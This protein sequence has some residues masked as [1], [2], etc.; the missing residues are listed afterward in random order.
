MDV[1]FTAHN[2]RL[3][4]G[5]FTNPKQIQIESHPWF[6]SARRVLE[7]VFPGDKKHIRIADL[8]CLEGGYTVGFARMGFDV[9]GIEIRD[10]NLAACEYVRS[11]TN[12]PNL[13]FVKDNALNVAKYGAFDAVFCC[14]LFYHLD[15]PKQFL[16]I[17]SSVTTKVLILQTHF[18]TNSERRVQS[19]PVSWW[20]KLWGKKKAEKRQPDKFN[21]SDL[22]ENEGL[23]GRWFVEF[24]N[25]ELFHNREA[26]RWASWDN[27]RSFWIQ[28]EFLLQA[29]QDAG[30]DLVMEQYDSLG[31][32]I[33][34]SMLQG[35]YQTDSRGTFIGIKTAKAAAV[36]SAAA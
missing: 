27:R 11:K 31:S 8:G 20:Q 28:R 33:A 12:L 18:S 5:T 6:I 25:D 32:K 9:L 17:L 24:E 23:P 13:K 10:S 21:L 19:P 16:Q 1:T 30:F 3:D 26:A 2:I 22:T 4:D 35:Y 34:Q 14:G 7:T 29:M 15:S 36:S